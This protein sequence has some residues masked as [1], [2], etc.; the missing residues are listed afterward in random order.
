AW[1]DIFHD[2][3]RGSS[4]SA[5]LRARMQ[6]QIEQAAGLLAGARQGEGGL[7]QGPLDAR[8]APREL[9]ELPGED[10]ELGEHALAQ[11]LGGVVVVADHGLDALLDLDAAGLEGARGRAGARA[12]GLEAGGERLDL[13]L[14]RAEQRREL[15]AA[16]GAQ[17]A[18]GLGPAARV[19][20]AALAR[21][22]PPPLPPAEHGGRVHL[23]ER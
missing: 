23:L 20:V 17:G 16:H 8:D 10:V 4:P 14:E 13:L 9:A 22:P 21:G 12:L 19:E 2:A 1:P 6:L 15:R 18:R 7:G 11:A 5:G 3:A